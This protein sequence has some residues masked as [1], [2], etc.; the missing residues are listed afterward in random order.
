MVSIGVDMHKRSW[1]I[2]VLAD[3][4]IV[5]TMSLTRPNYDAFEK[6]L[7]QFISEFFDNLRISYK[8]ND[9]HLTLAFRACQGI[10]LIDLLNQPGP[11]LSL[12]F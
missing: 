1:H 8:T 4:D 5:L 12:F 6:L 7:S 2:T 3:G 10:N 9:S 11:V